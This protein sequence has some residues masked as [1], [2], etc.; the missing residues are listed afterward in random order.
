MAAA[1]SA[2][3]LLL[4]AACARG[5]AIDAVAPLTS[6]TE[7]APSTEQ[8][9]A[10]APPAEAPAPVE[11]PKPESAVE[12]VGAAVKTVGAAVKTVGTAVESDADTSPVRAASETVREATSE[13]AHE[14][15]GAVGRAARTELNATVVTATGDR[16]SKLVGEI[17]QVATSTVTTVDD[18][19]QQLSGLSEAGVKKIAGEA[20]FGKP[21]RTEELLPAGTPPSG[22]LSS[23][24]ESPV[25]ENPVFLDKAPHAYDAGQP[26]GVLPRVH[27][28]GI[29]SSPARYRGFS[30]AGSSW[31][32]ALEG[33]DGIQSTP[34]SG[35]T[36]ARSNDP[37]PLDGPTP[38]PGSSGTAGSTGSSF[39]PLAALLALLAL[40]APATLRRLGEVPAF[41]P[42]I[43]FVCALER[44]G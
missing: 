4:T 22:A 33:L 32:A 31:F 18:R 19:T 36:G 21:P 30:G 6:A 5:E 20:A 12:T 1:I 2:I 39:V 38:A 34:M 14:A 41:R 10:P 43:P 15:T 37:A 11:T 24:S 28:G 25:S 35:T 40:V 3:L 44:P 17:G 7:D 29:S 13:A 42:P 23:P 9:S 16:A 8:A 27:L 26:A